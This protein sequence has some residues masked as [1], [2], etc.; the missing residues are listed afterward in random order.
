MFNS[1]CKLVV[2]QKSPLF[3]SEQ[4]LEL[5]SKREWHKVPFCSCPPGTKN[6]AALRSAACFHLENSIV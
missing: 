2:H 4:S 1:G 3:Y 5:R 6:S